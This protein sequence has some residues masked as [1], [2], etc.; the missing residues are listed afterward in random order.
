M[1]YILTARLL[2]FNLGLLKRTLIWK[3]WMFI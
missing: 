2:R 3:Q 1:N